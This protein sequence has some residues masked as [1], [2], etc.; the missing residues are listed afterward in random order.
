MIT[1]RFVFGYKLLFN[2]QCCL[3][4]SA[5]CHGSNKFLKKIPWL[6]TF[7]HRYFDCVYFVYTTLSTIND[8]SFSYENELLTLHISGT[9]TKTVVLKQQYF[10]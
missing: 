5:S 9:S 8:W 1:Y 7:T 4:K 10:N 3:F 6:N 2:K